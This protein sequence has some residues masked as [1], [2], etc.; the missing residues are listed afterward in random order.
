MLKCESLIAAMRCPSLCWVTGEENGACVKK[1][2]DRKGELFAFPAFRTKVTP[3]SR[4][5]NAN[6][7][8]LARYRA[9][10]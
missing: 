8:R 1:G 10:L 2:L 7:D 9:T 4:P 6:D 5:A 3:L